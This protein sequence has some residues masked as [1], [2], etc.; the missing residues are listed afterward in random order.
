[1]D[2]MNHKAEQT[3]QIFRMCYNF[4]CLLRREHLRE[5][6]KRRVQEVKPQIELS[7]SRSDLV[8]ARPSTLPVN[9]SA[10]SR[11]TLWVSLGPEPGASFII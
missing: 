3:E 7:Q 9:P 10:G 8:I 11:Y 5:K 1:M 6:R 2:L 4:K